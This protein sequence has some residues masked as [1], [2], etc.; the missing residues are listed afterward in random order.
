MSTRRRHAGWLGAAR[1]ASALALFVV[2]ADHLYEYSVD[3]YSAIPTIGVLFLLNAIGG[4]TLG[5]AALVPVERHFAPRLA[6]K[7]TVGI[8]SAGIALAAT[9]LIALFVSENTSLFGFMESGYRTSI[10]IAIVAEAAAIVCLVAV[11]ALAGKDVSRPIHR[12]QPG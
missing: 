7:M 3:Y 8:A 9:S 12:H 4:F 2:G 10:V 1:V 5:A 11:V 6:I